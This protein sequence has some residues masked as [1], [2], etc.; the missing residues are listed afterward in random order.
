MV[1]GPVTLFG[2]TGLPSRDLLVQ[3]K[4]SNGSSPFMCVPGEMALE[5][6]EEAACA[7]PQCPV[8]SSH[9]PLLSP[10]LTT[11]EN[12]VFICP[13]FLKSVKQVPGICSVC[14]LQ[15]E[16]D[17]SARSFVSCA[18]IKLNLYGSHITIRS[19]S[20]V[21]QLDFVFVVF[22]RQGFSV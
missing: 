21:V 2:P 19:S 12:A 9:R 20:Q 18:I 13:A 4:G 7:P 10:C 5:G 3:T 6:G 14:M 11:D 17:L 22:Q 15:R 8:F 16:T 1:L